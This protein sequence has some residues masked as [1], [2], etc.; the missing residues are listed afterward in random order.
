MRPLIVG[1]A[2]AAL[3]PMLI[4]F[5]APA[6]TTSS[7]V[8]S[9]AA[10]A[11]ADE[12]KAKYQTNPRGPAADRARIEEVVALLSAPKSDAPARERL[13]A[14]LAAARND[15]SLARSLRAELVAT[16]EMAE[17]VRQAGSASRE[18]NLAAIA[19]AARKVQAE[20]PDQPQGFE[21]LLNRL[22]KNAL[23]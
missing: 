23:F 9:A 21:S 17:A 3:T 15:T 11:R 5:S 7:E 2:L 19:A 10:V 8:R 16:Y 13:L 4:A 14:T 20:F 6:E 12:A 22:L 18:E 1:L